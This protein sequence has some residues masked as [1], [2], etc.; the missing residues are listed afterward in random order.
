VLH[1]LGGALGGDVDNIFFVNLG[2][3]EREGVKG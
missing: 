2:E 1:S 3:R